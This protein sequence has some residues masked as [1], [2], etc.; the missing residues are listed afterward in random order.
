MPDGDIEEG[1][2]DVGV[3]LRTGTGGQFGPGRLGGHG[4]LVAAHARHGVVAVGYG[5]DPS[6][7]GDL[8]SRQPVGITGAVV[9]LVVLGNSAGP[10]PQPA[11][12]RGGQLGP[13]DG[14]VL[15][16]HPLVVIKFVRL[17]QNVGVNGQLADVVEKS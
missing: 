17:V 6:S 12:Q 10:L 4:S 15:H 11:G 1:T 8:V 5:H 3:E 9:P 16:D 2:H 14:M 13:F 7:E